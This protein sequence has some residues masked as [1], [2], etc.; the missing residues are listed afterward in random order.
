MKIIF[1]YRTIPSDPPKTIPNTSVYATP[2]NINLSQ[3]LNSQTAGIQVTNQIEPAQIISSSDQNVTVIPLESDS[4][5][6]STNLSNI[7]FINQQ[8]QQLTSE[9]STIIQNSSTNV[10]QA[11][12]IIPLESTENSDGAALQSLL[13]TEVSNATFPTMPLPTFDKIIPTDSIQVL[14]DMT[15]L[16]DIPQTDAMGAALQFQIENIV[17]GYIE[18]YKKIRQKANID[19]PINID[20]TGDEDT[21]KSSDE[22]E[23]DKSRPIEDIVI[24]LEDGA[25]SLPTKRTS[26]DANNADDE[27][28]NKK[29]KIKSKRNVKNLPLKFDDK[30]IVIDD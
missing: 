16:A 21:F 3:I 19:N 12:Q 4:N 13:S 11:Y 14:N 8:N 22:N 25:S 26:T 15:P 9:S 6:N 27:P 24:P 20:L 30:L 7:V 29:K 17:G 2:N 10:Y 5:I 18:P 23:C 1:Y 28:L